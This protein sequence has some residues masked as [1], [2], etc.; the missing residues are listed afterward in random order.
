MY[1][2]VCIHT[3]NT[4]SSLYLCTHID[5]TRSGPDVLFDVRPEQKLCLHSVYIHTCIRIRMYTF[6]HVFTYVNT[7]GVVL[8]RI[9]F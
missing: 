7:L 6:T 5:Q 9:L 2:Y 1:V 8:F 3:H 4:H